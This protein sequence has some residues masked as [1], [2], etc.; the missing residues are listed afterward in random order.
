MPHF[1]DGSDQKRAQIV[2][3]TIDLIS[4]KW[5]PQ[6]LYSLEAEATRFNELKSNLDGISSKV[7]SGSL[8]DLQDNGLVSKSEE[9]YYLTHKGKEMKSALEYM[10]E[11]GEKFSGNETPEVLVVEDETSQ[12]RMYARWLE[13]YSVKTASNE[14]EI[15]EKLSEETAV[16]LLDRVLNTKESDKIA[17]D[18]KDMFPGIE[19][20]MITAVEPEADIVGLAV[21]DYLVKPVKKRKIRE[22]IQQSLEKSEKTMKKRK[23]LSMA[24]KKAVLDGKPILQDVE[25]YE[26]LTEEIRHLKSELD[27]EQDIPV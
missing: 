17:E 22:S 7:L 12:R 21:D 5:H 15:Y 2:R 8:S 18:I 13:D 9:G 25:K 14:T 6:I 3:S 10:A 19:I 27:D 20:I 26:K 16:I 23:L 11:W 1:P 24:A 4:K